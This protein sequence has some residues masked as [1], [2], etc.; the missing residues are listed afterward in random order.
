MAARQIK[1]IT[2]AGF[3][4]VFVV[5]APHKKQKTSACFNP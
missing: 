2:S 1:Q 5:F 4:A 3:L